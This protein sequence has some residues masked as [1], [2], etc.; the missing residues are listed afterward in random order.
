MLSNISK[1]RNCGISQG[2][3]IK[4]KQCRECIFVY[5]ALHVACRFN[6]NSLLWSYFFIWDVYRLLYSKRKLWLFAACAFTGRKTNQNVLYILSLKRSMPLKI[7]LYLVAAFMCTEWEFYFIFSFLFQVNSSE[8]NTSNCCIIQYVFFPPHNKI[9]AK[10]QQQED[11]AESDGALQEYRESQ[12]MLQMVSEVWVEPQMGTVDLPDSPLSYIHGSEYNK[13]PQKVCCCFTKI[14]SYDETFTHVYL[15]AKFTENCFWRFNPY[16]KSDLNSLNRIQI[17]VFKS[18]IG[19]MA[20]W[21]R[22]STRNLLVRGLS[23]LPVTVARIN[24]RC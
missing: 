1:L 18:L 2:Q 15:Y 6:K 11:S 13:I 3:N 19:A 8:E 14:L 9:S 16:S 24:S 12:D 17:Y 7:F 20:E 21:L 4:K 23:S 5:I 22:Y 10:Q